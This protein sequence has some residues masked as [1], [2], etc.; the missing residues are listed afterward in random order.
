MLKSFIQ[1][2]YV[3]HFFLKKFTFGPAGPGL[4][5]VAVFWAEKISNVEVVDRLGSVHS[6]EQ[7]D[8]ALCRANCDF[9]N[10]AVFAF[11]ELQNA[12]QFFCLQVQSLHVEVGSH[13]QE[14][15][16]AGHASDIKVFQFD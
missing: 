16:E 7:M 12:I 6:T 14:V 10:N 11:V 2:L 3:F 1:K 13:E 4:R 15:S 9:S 5:R 8:A